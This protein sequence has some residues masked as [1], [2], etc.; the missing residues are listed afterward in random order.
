M[1]TLTTFEWVLCLQTTPPDDAAEVAAHL[2][3]LHRQRKQDAVF[4][5]GGVSTKALVERAAQIVPSMFRSEVG[6]EQ[7]KK[8][9]DLDLDP[10]C[11]SDL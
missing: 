11:K 6:R 10:G 2:A 8:K 4:F 1:E 9:W 5:S 7:I 3:L